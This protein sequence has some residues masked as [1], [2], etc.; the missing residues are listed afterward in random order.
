MSTGKAT[1]KSGDL[2]VSQGEQE[3]DG[4]LPT[5][6]VREGPGQTNPAANKGGPIKLAALYARVS[7]EKQ[8][9]EKTI[10]SQVAVLSEAIRQAPVQLLPEYIFLDDGESGANL[11][12]PALE[13][14]RDKA[15]EGAFEVLYVYAPDR[16]ARN[17]PYQVLLLEEFKRDGVEVVFLNHQFGETPGEQMLLQM[18]GVFAEYERALINE[19][20]RR[21]RLYA[22]RQGRYMGSNAPYGYRYIPKSE[23]GV[24][25]L[26]INETDAEVVRQM[27]RWLIEEE[28]SSAEIAKRLSLLGI[29]TR[30]G[31]KK[32]WGQSTVIDILR[33]P[34]YKG[35]AYYN[36][37]MQADAVTPRKERSFK[38]FPVGNNR[39]KKLRAEEEWITIRVPEFFTEEYWQEAQ[40][41]LKQ[42]SLRSKRNNKREYLLRGLLICAECGRRMCGRNGAYI[43]SA[44]YAID[45]EERCRGETMNGERI[46]TQVWEYISNL[47]K[48]EEL[49][50]S[51]YEEQGADPAINEKEE[52]EKG[53]L[54]RRSKGLEVQKQRL[55]DGYQEGMIELKELQKRMQE[56]REEEG[57]LRKRIAEIARGRT[58]R[59]EGLRVLEGVK[60]FCESVRGALTNPDFALKQKLLRL[61]VDKIIVKKNKITIHHIIPTAKVILQPERVLAT[62]GGA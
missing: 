1:L 6:I 43:C 33:N 17:Y 9:K 39:G 15:Y 60:V 47:L 46:E 4:S 52:A 34:V 53:H 25:H 12:R 26:E 11:R 14:L 59:E 18:Q 48:D 32:Q 28:M 23:Q 54:E 19:R 42:N 8:E 62:P 36:R 22:A 55:L 56:I 58:E 24:Q 5:V 40:E 30:K 41:Q 13:K 61:V 7:S 21:G 31:G 27:Y 38:D 57:R 29:K 44:R 3:D 51:Y 49:L 2:F 10:D 37:T 35:Q 20:T 45:H 16:L 50:R